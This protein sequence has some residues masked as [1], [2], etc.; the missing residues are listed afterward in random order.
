MPARL[1][2]SRRRRPAV[3]AG[4]NSECSMGCAKAHAGAG[5]KSAAKK[6][7]GRARP[8]LTFMLA[9]RAS[10]LLDRRH[11]P[12]PAACAQ[13]GPHFG[14]LVRA[15]LD[16]AAALALDQMVDRE[17][18]RVAEGGPHAATEVWTFLR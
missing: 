16:H 11:Q 8:F 17:S 4:R 6:W 15:T 10:R 2:S 18:G 13:E 12:M 14:G 5:W 7:P 1:S 3:T 9:A